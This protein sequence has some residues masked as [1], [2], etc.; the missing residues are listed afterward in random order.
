[1]LLRTTSRSREVG[2][3][4]RRVTRKFDG[5]NCRSPV[6]SFRTSAKLREVTGR[7]GRT[8][9]ATS[10]AN[11]LAP[12]RV[13]IETSLRMSEGEAGLS[14]DPVDCRDGRPLLITV[15]QFQG[16]ECRKVVSNSNGRP[17]EPRNKAEDRVCDWDFDRFIA[18]VRLPFPR[19]KRKPVGGL[20]VPG[21][22]VESPR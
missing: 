6:N 9:T 17:F 10:P 13:A 19:P 16:S 7:S 11:K 1:M 20:H 12:N 21:L 8:T 4:I 5:Q 18:I 14:E 2:A 3:R 22:A 15:F